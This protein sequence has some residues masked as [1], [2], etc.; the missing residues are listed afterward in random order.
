M[1]V[2]DRET[3][4]TSVAGTRRAREG[5]GQAAG[6]RHG[7]PAGARHRRRMA[8]AQSAGRAA[9]D[10]DAARARREVYQVSL[11]SALMAGVYDGPTTIGSLLEHGSFGVGTFEALDGE[12]I[13]L[14][15]HCYRMRSDGSATLVGQSE[16]TPFAS[17]SDFV[18][19]ESL[20][21]P[22]G[23][24]QEQVLA[25]VDDALGSLN[26]PAGVRLTGTFASVATRTVQR[27]SRPYPP[28]AEATAG[29]EVRHWT[30]FA[31]V[32]SGFFTPGYL[33]SVS[34]PGYHLHALDDARMHGGHVL[35]FRVEHATAQICRLAGLRVALPSEPGFARA[36]LDPAD[37][38]EQMERIE[39]HS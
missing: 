37:L 18:A 29:E 20:A 22:D 2:D 38:A 5:Q 35:D 24:T 12:M 9:E 28:M 3:A 36:E 7:Q 25:L 1:R 6:K 34:V 26:Y 33:Q 14:D 32:I 23:A 13:V 10:R 31:G 19:D 30:S 39:R 8:A 15:G 4:P 17:V 21:I 11:M 27:Q 16:R